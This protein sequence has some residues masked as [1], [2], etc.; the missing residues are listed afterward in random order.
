M[1]RKPIIGIPSVSHEMGRILPVFT[2]TGHYIAAVQ[3]AG[4]VPVQL[5]IT[6]GMGGSDVT[7]MLDVCDGI[8]LP[9]GRDFSPSLY[10]QAP[11]PG[12]TPG[13]QAIDIDTQKA[14]LAF[15][16]AAAGSGKPVLGICLGMQ[17]L[18]IAFGGDLWQD[19]PTQVGSMVCHAQP[20]R[21][22]ADRWLTA[23]TVRIAPD[24]LLRQ[25]TR[26]D[27]IAVNSFHHQAVKTIADGFA[28]TAWAPDGVVEAMEHTVYPVLG[29]QWHPE[30]LAYG[31]I[32]HAKT[33]SRWLVQH[34]MGK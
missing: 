3:A 5:P 10:G 16:R 24:S 15:V 2:T 22:T 11:L 23:H 19:I 33:L 20:A 13:L 8:L 31:G 32:R 4:G 21:M 1:D 6:A 28:P 26:A 12:Q 14:A 27:E 30:N 18:N 9:G 25:L 17:L 29:V 7:S 34:R